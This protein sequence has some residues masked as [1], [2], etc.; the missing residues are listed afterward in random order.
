VTGPVLRKIYMD[1]IAGASLQDLAVLSARHGGPHGIDGLR[2]ALDWG[3]GAGKIRYREQVF[4]G[5][6]EGVITEEEFKRYQRARKARAKRQRAEPAEHTLSGILVCWCG[7]RMWGNSRTVNG[8]DHTRYL[9]AVRDETGHTPHTNSISAAKA[10]AAVLEWLRGFAGQVNAS[11]KVRPRKDGSAAARRALEAAAS[12]NAARIDSLT[13][14]FL[15]GDVDKEAYDRLMA[16][17]RSEKASLED[18]IAE[19]DARASA[20]AAAAVVPD[21]IA[22]WDRMPA[23]VKRQILS[24]LL[25]KV[26]VGKAGTPNRL[27]FVPK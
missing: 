18:Q 3:F 27:D 19:L 12:K 4:E 24:A 21:L 17:Y 7:Q 9:C 8:V 13:E 1:Y 22:S 10:E 5:A 15:D 23:R 14:K 2:Y 25:E 16:K 6:H 20:P 11:V 26:V